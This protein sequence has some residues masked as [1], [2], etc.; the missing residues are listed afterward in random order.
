MSILDDF[1]KWSIKDNTETYERVVHVSE[2]HAWEAATEL[3]DVQI[4]ELEEIITSLRIAIN[5]G[6]ELNRQSNLKYLEMK[7]EIKLLK[8]ESNG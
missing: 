4:K 6:E 1:V 5:I 2:W 7:K 8:G 3:K